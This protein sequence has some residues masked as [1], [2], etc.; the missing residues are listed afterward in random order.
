A[1]AKYR[2]HYGKAKLPRDYVVD[3]IWETPRSFKIR[4]IEKTPM[5]GVA[6]FLDPGKTEMVPKRSI[7]FLNTEAPA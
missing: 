4:A 1:I 7:I 3:V 5:A 2:T 6:R